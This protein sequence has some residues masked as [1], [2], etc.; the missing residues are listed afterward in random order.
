MGFSGRCHE[1]LDVNV[2]FD[3]GSMRR[4][5]LAQLLYMATYKLFTTYALNNCLSWFDGKFPYSTLKNL[6]RQ[7]L[8]LLA[9]VSFCLGPVVCDWFI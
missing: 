7:D 2:S 9:I 1:K 8:L 6:K 4:D 3:I 5:D